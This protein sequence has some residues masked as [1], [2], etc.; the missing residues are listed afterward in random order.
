MNPLSCDE[1]VP[2]RQRGPAAA[3]IVLALVLGVV[4]GLGWGPGGDRTAG[5]A[6]GEP[7]PPVTV[8]PGPTVSAPTETAPPVEPEETV[9]AW[10]PPPESVWTPESTAPQ[11]QPPAEDFTATVPATSVAQQSTPTSQNAP[12][13]TTENLLI[14]PSTTPAPTTTL[15]RRSLSGSSVTRTDGSS[16][17]KVWGIVGALTAVG[18]GLGLATFFYWRRTDPRAE[19][20]GDLTV[21]PSS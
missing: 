8:D 7:D 14:G 2:R 3:V 12:M 18:L 19:S 6:R 21:T 1:P 17:P 5:A 9:P 15:A 4:G 20:P 10:T 16:D 11:W 13:T